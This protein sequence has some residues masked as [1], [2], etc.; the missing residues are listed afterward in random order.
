MPFDS[1]T[2]LAQYNGFEFNRSTE[3]LLFEG[4][5]ELDSSG[6][7]I[8]FIVYTIRLRTI[9]QSHLP[10]VTTD[11]LM[12]D[13]RNRLLVQGRPLVYT[14][15][16]AG[17]MTVNVGSARDVVWGPK[18]KIVS[19]KSIGTGACELVWEVEVA[20]PQCAGAAYS[21]AIMEFN[22]SLTFSIDAAGYTTRTYRGHIMI[23]QNRWGGRQVRE[24][25]DAY[26][27]EVI[28]LIPPGFRLLERTRH[29]DESKGRLDFV[30]VH[31]EMGLNIPP[32]GIV[33]CKASHSIRSGKQL[34]SLEWI[35]T[36]TAEYETAKDVDTKICWQHFQRLAI[37][38]CNRSRAQQGKGVIIPLS[39]AVREPE[40]YGRRIAQFE[41]T[42]EL[43]GQSIG[44]LLQASGL[45]DQAP[46]SN[47]LKW[48]GSLKNGAFAPR[49]TAKLR[50]IPTDDILLDLCN[51]NRQ[52]QLNT[53][54]IPTQTRRLSTAAAIADLGC[55]QP[56]QSWIYYDC[57]VEFKV[58]DK[59][60]EHK[61][62]PVPS[63]STV[64]PIGVPPSNPNFVGPVYAWA[65][66][67][68]HVPESVIHRRTEDSIEVYLVGKALRAC[69]DIPA[70][71]I[72][73]IGDMAVVESNRTDHGEGFKTWVQHDYFGISVIAAQW[74]I[75]YILPTRP[76]TTVR[77]VAPR[78]EPKK[79]QRK[80]SAFWD[81]A[82]RTPEWHAEAQ[83]RMTPLWIFPKGIE[84]K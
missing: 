77:L 80:F 32:P 28:P 72:A 6:R 21:N 12:N 10:G 84:D 38:R 58:D 14:G 9:L 79:P 51:A 27:E 50:H 29:L 63:S 61:P 78:P 23:P 73:K 35:A 46:D 30:I 66:V 39:F 49:G 44:G 67:L 4:R 52:S 56:D 74:K 43:V 70:P 64:V 83:R 20:V 11:A 45:W 53:N 31:Q 25:A 7:T 68:P 48:T 57:K 75:R 60:V 15:V 5:P 16:G 42:Y 37:E 33:D 76:K 40:I 13:A 18:P 81:F 55:P 69:Y 19:Y 1:S 2:V 47:W 62:L 22:Y 3:T 8:K 65:T 26:W 24:T 59:V 41:L 82:E 36:I 54:P 17:N 71:A 34:P